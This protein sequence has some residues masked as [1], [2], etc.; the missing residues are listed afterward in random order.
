MRRTSKPVS[1]DPLGAGRSASVSTIMERLFESAVHLALRL[2]GDET[3]FYL[4]IA[5]PFGVLLGTIASLAILG[6]GFRT[7]LKRALRRLAG[8]W[9]RVVIAG[10]LGVFGNLVYAYFY[11]D[12]YYVSGDSFVDFIPFCLWLP[13]DTSWGGHPIYG[14]APIVILWFLVASVCWGTAIVLARRLLPASALP[15][16][17]LHRTYSRNLLD[18]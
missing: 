12:S 18:R 3:A 14:V 2:L 11:R 17:A 7:G 1:L 15:N 4:F 8:V 13:Y 5:V 6:A 9:L 16:S 10:S